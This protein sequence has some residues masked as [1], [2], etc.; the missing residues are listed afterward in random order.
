MRIN[1]DGPMSGPPLPDPLAGELIYM[2][3]IKGTGMAA[4]AEILVARGAQ[5][6]GSDVEERFYTDALLENAGISF[7]E[8]FAADNVRL[9]ARHPDIVIHSAAYDPQ[10]HPELV[11][12]RKM[13]LPI[14]RYT[15]ALG[16]LSQCQ[17]SV[18]IAGVHGKTTTTAM[19][20]SIARELGLPGTVLAGSALADLGG[21][22]TLVQGSEF[23]VA[24]TCEYRRN[25]LSF[26]PQAIV[27]TSVEPDHL[28]YYRDTDDIEEAFAEYGARLATG[29]TLVYCADDAG[30]R[31]VA[32]RIQA[33]RPDV[34]IVPYGLTASG[35]GAVTVTGR[36][37]GT[38]RCTIGGQPYELHVPGDH[39][40][41]N[42]AAALLVALLLSVW[43]NRVKSGVDSEGASGQPA[44][45]EAAF[46]ATAA[47]EALTRAAAALAGFRGTRRR[48]ELVGESAGITILDDYA[49]HPTA[50]ATTLAGFRA[51]YPNRRIVL[52]F[53]SHTYSRTLALLEEFGRALAAADVVI[54]HDI[55]ASAR[56]DNPGEVDGEV[57]AV[58][59]HR[60]N[61]H[62]HYVAGVLD[63]LPLLER[64]IR[65]GDLFVT[66]GAGNNW[67]LGPRL[68]ELLKV[69]VSQ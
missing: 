3:G 44:G 68:L 14:I 13:G 61:E 57:L 2:V 56:E 59:A 41:L 37:A 10:S 50:I 27:I 46:G 67:Q 26:S 29:G 66:M 5:V 25:F 43:T 11:E 40:V 6:T 64:I 42:A 15:E 52:S 19:I 28:D 4:L 54:V 45:S 9:L 1:Y 47:D 48:A 17:P 36:E 7:R 30:A 33:E 16:Q 62:V 24:E 49:H 65:P 31:T 22:A 18:G 21:R 34:K 60:Y 55:Y 69:E 12:A 38:V 8:G 53:M 32:N 39:N 35:A 51:F 63:A 20:A 23:F 58:A